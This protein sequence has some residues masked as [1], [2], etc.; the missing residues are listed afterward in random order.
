M[1]S[2]A[3][4]AAEKVNEMARPLGTR[5]QPKKQGCQRISRHVVQAGPAHLRRLSCLLPQAKRSAVEELLE[6]PA[7]L[8]CLPSQMR[9]WSPACSGEAMR[10]E[11]V[12][13]AA[14]RQEKLVL[15]VPRAP[16]AALRRSSYGGLVHLQMFWQNARMIRAG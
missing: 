12:M 13:Q 5:M 3:A 16:R 4:T 10:G 8:L 6:C 2:E 7:D 15:Y 11:K 1:R 14:S 9:S